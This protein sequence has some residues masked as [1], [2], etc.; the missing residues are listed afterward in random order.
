MPGERARTGPIPDCPARALTTRAASA[1]S[2][3]AGPAGMT[4]RGA[5]TTDERCPC[6]TVRSCPRSVARALQLR[7]DMHRF[8][9]SKSRW[10]RFIG[11]LANG[12]I[13]ALASVA[14]RVG[15]P[16]LVGVPVS[17]AILT[18]VVAV[19]PEQSLD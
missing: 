14:H 17:A 6:A 8:E 16:T 12:A 11:D 2:S 19:R 4:V 13:A 9:R 15:A 7:S 1:N 3:P 5:H 18:R 10:S